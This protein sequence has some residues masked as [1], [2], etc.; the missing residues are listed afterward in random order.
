MVCNLSLHINFLHSHLDVF[1]P[2]LGAVSDEHGERFCQDFS[3]MEKNTQD[4]RHRTLADCCWNLT[5]EVSIARYKRMSFKKKFFHVTKIKHLF[6]HFC[7][8]TARRYF[9]T[10]FLPLF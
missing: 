8:V 3:T 4:K 9:Q 5:E 1:P 7:C 10:T 6:S 2:N